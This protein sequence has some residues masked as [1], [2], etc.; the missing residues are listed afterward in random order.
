MKRIIS[1]VLSLSIL[2]GLFSGLEM[3]VFATTSN[4][5]IT[6][7]NEFEEHMIGSSFA[8]SSSYKSDTYSHNSETISYEISGP[9]QGLILDGGMSCIGTPDNGFISIPFKAAKTGTYIVTIS[10]IY[11]ATD[12][13]EI[14]VSEKTFNVYLASR[15]IDRKETVKNTNMLYHYIF[16]EPIDAA[17]FMSSW[18]INDDFKANPEYYYETILL[19]LLLKQSANVN[20]IDYLNNNVK[21]ISEKCISY[22]LDYFKDLDEVALKASKFSNMSAKDIEKLNE[23]FEMST[24]INNIWS[25][26]S[27]FTDGVDTVEDYFNSLAK[28]ATLRDVNHS[29]IDVLNLIYVYAVQDSE[30]NL[31]SA[32]LAGACDKLIEIYSN[33]NV[34]VAECF[35]NSAETI[36]WNLT[37]E[38][39]SEAL[40]LIF[41]EAAA[42]IEITKDVSLIMANSIFGLE[43]SIKSSCLVKANNYIEKYIKQGLDGI[44]ASF[45]NDQETYSE[46][47]I[48]C[49]ELLI[50]CFQY[51]NAVHTY[52]AAL[53]YDKTPAG[54]IGT[55]INS[56]DKV[57][58]EDMQRCFVKCDEMIADEYKYIESVIGEYKAYRYGN[59]TQWVITLNTNDEFGFETDVLVYDGDIIDLS[60]RIPKR[61][62][63]KFLG[64]YYDKE[65]TIPLEENTAATTYLTLYANWEKEYIVV[66]DYDE[67]TKTPFAEISYMPSPVTFSLSRNSSEQDTVISIPAYVDGYE[68]SK[69]SDYG[70]AGNSSLVSIHIPNT[71]T[72]IGDYGFSN[73]TSLIELHIPDT[74]VYIGEDILYNCNVQSL[75]IFGY[76][77]PYAETYATQKGYNFIDIN[78]QLFR[79]SFNDYTKK[80]TI[81]GLVD[82]YNPVTLTIP[83]KINGYTVT[84]VSQD[85]FKG[86]GNLT[87]VEISEGITSI[88]RRC[89][90]NCGNLST[91]YLPE[92]L[93][94]IGERAFDYCNNLERVYITNLA[95]WCGINFDGL[96]S[97]PLYYA[98]ALLL[99]HSVLSG[100]I[101]LPSSVVEIP[102]YTFSNSKV[103]QVILPDSIESIGVNAFYNCS[104]LKSINLPDGISVIGGG[105]FSRCSSLTQIE[106]PRGISGII[107][108]TFEDCVKLAEITIPRNVQKIGAYAFSGCQSLKKVNIEDIASWCLMDLWGY[109][110]TSPLAY[111]ADLYLNGEKLETLNIPDNITILY[112]YTFAG[113]GSIVN[114]IVPDTVTE[115]E[116]SV[117]R[118]C[119]NLESVEISNNVTSIG[120]SCFAYCS[121]LKNVNIPLNLTEISGSMFYGCSGLEEI[122]IPDNITHIGLYSFRDC[123]SLKSII[124][125]DS[126]TTLENYAFE[127]ASSLKYIDIGDGVS[128]NIYG[129]FAGC[130][131]IETIIIGNGITTIE[132]PANNYPGIFENC[133]KLKSVTLGSNLQIL[134][135]ESFSGCISLENINIPQSVTEIPKYAFNG[136]SSLKSINLPD[137]CIKIGEGAFNGCTLLSE[138]NIPKELVIIGDSAFQNCGL[139]GKLIIHNN[140]EEIGKNAFK[141]CTSL[142]G[143]TIGNKVTDI[144]YGTFYGCNSLQE[145]I[146]SEGLLRIG[147]DLWQTSDSRYEGAFE[148]CSSLKEISLPDSLVGIA[149]NSFRDC[150]AL[151]IISIPNSI[152]VVEMYTFDGCTSLSDISLPDNI[153]QLHWNA[154]Y[155]TAIY[156]EAKN[157]NDNVLYIDNCLIQAKEGVPENYTILDDTIIIGTAAFQY[158]DL[159]SVVIPQSVKNIGSYAFYNVDSWFLKDIFYGGTENDWNALMSKSSYIG[160]GDSVRVHFETDVNHYTVKELQEETCTEE[161]KTIYGCSCG[162]EKTEYI[163][164]SGHN[165]E[166]VEKTEPTCD[167]SGYTMYY[168]EKC[169]QHFTD[170]YVDALGHTEDELIESVLPTC[171][172]K[173]YNKYSCS[174]CDSEFYVY[175]DKLEHIKEEAESNSATCTVGAT[176]RYYCSR[177]D[178]YIWEESGS[179][180]GHSFVVDICSIC[181]VDNKWIYHFDASTG[182]I[183]IDGYSGSE[184]SIVIPAEIE[185][186]S[187]TC[188]GE[189]AFS[190]NTNIT[191]VIFPESLENI[192]ICAF[193]GCSNISSITIPE[194]VS[195]IGDS[196]FDDTN[197]RTVVYNATKCYM[198]YYDK[199]LDPSSVDYNDSYAVWNGF[200]IFPNCTEII[201]GDNV[202]FIPTSLV[203]N[204]T[205]L[206]SITLPENLQRIQPCAFRACTN[207]VNLTFSE[208]ISSIGF[209]AFENTLWLDNQPDGLLY[210]GKVLYDFIG[211]GGNKVISIKGGTV[212]ISDNALDDCYNL[213]SL[214]IPDSLVSVGNSALSDCYSLS[215]I[216]YEGSRQDWSSMKIGYSN[217]ILESITK[218]YDCTSDVLVSILTKPTCEDD[219]NIK[220]T[221]ELCE[222]EIIEQLEALGHNGV[223]IE[224]IA[225]TCTNDGY[226]VYQCSE[227]G[228]TYNADWV[229]ST[230]HTKGDVVESVVPSCTQDGYTRYNCSVCGVTF[231]TDCVWAQGHTKD[232][233]VSVVDPTCEESGYTIYSCSICSLTFKSDWIYSNGHTQGAVIEV[234]EA[235][236]T[237]DGYTKYQCSSCEEEFIDNWTYAS[238][239]N[240]DAIDT[241]DAT[242]IEKGYTEHFCDSCG[243][244]YNSDFTAPIGHAFENDVCVNCHKAKEDCIESSHNYENNCDGT[245]II[246]KPNAD[247]ITITF[248]SATETERGWDYIYI[249]DM[250]DNLIGQYSGTELA[251]QTI[252]VTGNIVKIRLTSD[253][254]VNKYGFAVSD[255]CSY[256]KITVNDVEVA[257]PENAV[258]STAELRVD[259][260]DINNIVVVLP[261]E[262]DVATANVYD[263]YF[264]KDEQRVQPNGAVTVYIPVSSDMDGE[265][266][267]VFHIDESGNATD[268]NAVYENGYMV[269]TTEH[270]SYYAL[271]EEQVGFVYGDANGDTVIDGRDVVRLK[272]YLAN[273]DYDTETSTV[274]IFDGADANGDGIIDGRDVIRL[275]NYLANYDYDTDS[276]TV[277]LGPQN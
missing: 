108:D 260:I 250:D 68:I 155:N 105:A 170:D 15:L 225:P 123:T 120:G 25:G 177:G 32:L 163:P 7:S 73:C 26:V 13:I 129:V 111:G 56:N 273:Y 254:S 263:I 18:V 99:N 141:S 88:G 231:T 262:F 31:N 164:A 266:C 143:I 210:I 199:Y 241:I 77:D 150:T 227:C 133:K 275:K 63:Y 277:I 149:C 27:A 239:H 160:I 165:Y 158:I 92:S 132:R 93:N 240:G 230:G 200:S 116:A 182:G 49:H 107:S 196:A 228:E 154:F 21:D 43:D 184:T 96:I 87:E 47:Y 113:C 130:D 136:C 58:Y 80:A 144:Y 4:T 145:V 104:F 40:S 176:T 270:F 85:A 223:A 146:L 101:E 269:F 178:H 54:K 217:T 242:C 142:E 76:S 8:V 215:H 193:Q 2:M 20:Y 253:S 109:E 41:G 35:E 175:I 162:Y 11:G 221:C 61:N 156:N 29:Y 52:Y 97:N 189:F 37:K 65:C 128:R 204:N 137:S 39:A 249:Y 186:Y 1:L 46:E 23:S 218:H 171:T 198:S 51:G 245:W 197:I 229:Y 152:S 247:Y 185:G 24:G 70:F 183:C 59:T 243:E 114:V 57:I 34:G 205:N 22:S 214:F 151:A 38:V 6:I 3:S 180:N 28:Y 174:V 195:N 265:K 194:K 192:G 103:E 36:I 125:P 259:E 191:S 48:A 226:T 157:W 181:G 256:I 134:G 62:G 69:I 110:L 78:S 71:V 206:T 12:S 94:Y 216:I 140:V 81:S 44:S 236:C 202:T 16:D 30:Y 147:Y 60:S 55:F 166:F 126:V 220:Y 252:T 190:G 75:T 234:V 168:C 209:C 98:D 222:L 115:I 45:K 208:N 74:V 276:S 118:E 172:Q 267:K 173:G 121:A 131:E 238:G 201:F 268:M 261:E 91:I 117:F 64:W 264:E 106:L 83:S 84:N 233:I 42:L 159:C 14:L 274:G 86:L 179:G 79:Y 211:Y 10:S 246:S 139:V 9:E 271:V 67:L 112:E 17:D 127:D 135:E 203:A 237:E 257:M 258:D 95:S 122:V 272:N 66:T 119:S 90:Q 212:S 187:V 100:K 5:T 207:L 138:V 50:S 89:F 232:E 53:L 102:D 19:D 235:T 251:S 219:G 248:S 169:D 213:V 124:I 255:I 148:G 244:I 33:K 161:G 224:T 82:G 153:T 167:W 188:I 72:H